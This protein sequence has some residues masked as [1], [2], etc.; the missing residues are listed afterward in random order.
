MLVVGFID[1]I[2]RSTLFPQLRGLRSIFKI[3]K[4]NQAAAAKRPAFYDDD[5]VSW[6]D[7][8]LGFT[9]A[10]VPVHQRHAAGLPVDC[11]DGDLRL[12]D[13]CLR[14]AASHGP[15]R[16]SIGPVVTVLGPEKAQC[17]SKFFGW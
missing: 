9:V 2:H 6:N 10:R 12:G 17:G 15:M 5:S 4:F 3:G 16:L 7:T 1:H 8:K 14:L 13:L 11:F